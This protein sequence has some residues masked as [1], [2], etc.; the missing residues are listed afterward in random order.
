MH[1]LLTGQLELDS[2]SLIFSQINSKPFKNNNISVVPSM[3]A[4][5]ELNWV[6]ENVSAMK[7][8]EQLLGIHPLTSVIPDPSTDQSPEPPPDPSPDPFP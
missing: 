2:H 4:Q 3:Q 6:V 5:R 7:T 8:L 1:A